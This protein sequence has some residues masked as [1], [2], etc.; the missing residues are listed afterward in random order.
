MPGDMRKGGAQGW[1]RTLALSPPLCAI[2][3]PRPNV[4]VGHKGGAVS[5][6]LRRARPRADRAQEPP[7]G[8]RL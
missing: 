8:A 3:R 2:I 5:A 1:R 4:R 7:H 6:A